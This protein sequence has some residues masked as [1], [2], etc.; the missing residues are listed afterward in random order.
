[1]QYYKNVSAIKNPN[2]LLFQIGEKVSK[3][4]R[5]REHGVAIQQ[6]WGGIGFS[7]CGQKMVSQLGEIIEILPMPS[8]TKVH[9][10]E[11]WMMGVTN[12]RGALVTLIDLEKLCG[13]SLTSNR[14]KMRVLVVQDGYTR[15]GLV[16]KNVFGLQSFNVNDFTSHD[17]H[18]QELFSK[19]V[20]GEI[21]STSASGHKKEKWYRFSMQKF[22]GAEYIG[23]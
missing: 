8:Y 22:L 6:T 16:V 21:M 19:Y 12:V 17:D 9:G 20:D 11:S 3:S 2:D 5:A 18:S 15:I 13:S 14:Q 4:I 1:M 10:A 7:L 23:V